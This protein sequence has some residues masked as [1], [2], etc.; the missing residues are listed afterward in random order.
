MRA[1]VVLD[2]AR[3]GWS[4]MEIDRRLPSY[5]VEH[6]ELVARVYTW[7]PPA[8]SLGRGEPESDV[9]RSLAEA[10][11]YNVVR[12]PSGGRAIVHG[13]HEITYS[14]AAPTPPAPTGVSEA[15][16]WAAG[17][18]AGA[19]N[20]LGVPA[21]P[22]GVVEYR[23]RGPI[24]IVAEGSGD[25]LVGVWKVAASAALIA[26]GAVMV[27]GILLLHLD[28]SLWAALIAEEPGRAYR[29]LNGSV[30]GLAD[31][32]YTVTPRSLAESIALG[33][34]ERGYSVERSGLPWE[35]APSTG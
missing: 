6:G 27:H 15:A 18:I 1:R 21:R 11:G 30:R 32:G 24:C 17:I 19:L 26:R 9:R 8:V 20:R 3:D 28:P 29:M 10:L 22:R 5:A 2:G 35:L 16:A 13:P 7:R 23:P 31:L 25:I 34:E 14:V 33:L 12:R 4:H